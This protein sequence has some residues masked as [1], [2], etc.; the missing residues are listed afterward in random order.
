MVAR[1]GLVIALAS[2]FTAPRAAAASDFWDAVRAPGSSAMHVHVQ[3][4]NRALAMNQ[5]SAALHE[6]ELALGACGQCA[7]ALV[8]HGR[9]LSALGRPGEALAQLQRALERDPAALDA[10][11]AALAAANSA[12]AVDQPKLAIHVLQRVLASAGDAGGRGRALIMLADALQAEG[13]AALDQAIAT[14]RDA[15]IEADGDPGAQIGL[16]LALFRKGEHDSALAL[17]R[18]SDAGD[19]ERAVFARALPPAEHA[20]RIAL[21]RM[22]R[23]DAAAAERAWQRASEGGGPWSEHARGALAGANVRGKAKAR[24]RVER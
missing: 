7:P 4:S 6:A 9:A 19:I 22:A 13:P 8:L 3:A 24:T 14:Y 23:D 17:A 12:L 20:A 21:L 18:R 11:P 16:A 5:A 2:P 15:T 1:T 10:E